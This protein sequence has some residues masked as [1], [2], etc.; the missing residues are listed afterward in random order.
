MRTVRFLPWTC[1]WLACSAPVSE[2]VVEGGQ[3]EDTTGQHLTRR[4]GALYQGG[5]PDSAAVLMQSLLDAPSGE[6]SAKARSTAHNLLGIHAQR[7][8]RFDESIA[9]HK[10]ALA[11]CQELG[12]RDCM[13]R[14]HV[15]LCNTH[16]FKGDHENALLHAYEA[17]RIKEEQADSA[18]LA[19]AHHNLAM[20]HQEQ[21]DLPSA[22]RALAA[23]LAIK[24]RM[25]DSL[26]VRNTLSVMSLVALDR[27]DH[28]GAVL[29]LERAHAI[30]R[31]HEDKGSMVD[32]HTNLGLAH[33]GAGRR[34]EAMRWFREAMEAVEEEPNDAHRAIIT[35]NIGRMLMEEG[36]VAEAGPW[37]EESLALARDVGALLDEKIGLVALAAQ[38]KAQ[39]RHSE[40][41]ELT[42]QLLAVNDSLLNERNQH[43]M[44]ELRVQYDTDRRDAENRMLLQANALAEAQLARQR[45]IIL[46]LVG[47]TLLVALV[48][49]LLVRAWR[50]RVDMRV[51]EL[52]QQALRAQM[53][54]HFLFNALN[55]VPGLY[56][57]HG[58]AMAT[59]YIGHLG[60]LLRLIL[61]SSAQ[62]IVSV[63]EER[64]LLEHY[65]QVMSLRHPGRFTW[66]ITV[67]PSIDA[68]NSGLPPMLLQPLVENAVLH[69][70]LKGEGQGH[71][72]VH[73]GQDR[74]GLHGR[75]RDNGPGL[76]QPPDVLR[77]AK[78]SGLRITDERIRL[79]NGHA[80]RGPGLV[81]RTMHD[82]QGA[83][84]GTEASFTVPITDIWDQ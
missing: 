22:D 45:I 15:N 41:L 64:E 27:G 67:D 21:G 31:E 66:A 50:R 19:R 82:G 24:E 65:L 4:A 60:Q 68:K 76:A 57:S 11:V 44:N 63:Q 35:G 58:V 9:H 54:P 73:I 59:D 5:Y 71:V 52:E 12:D 69:G 3:Q 56:H 37:L 30:A 49:V 47:G 1:L 43:S 2:A 13:G 74:H 46:T 53:D 32:I 40:A 39:G 28:E 8:G 77:C 23:S 75:V 33:D 29:L 26:G 79:G 55:T 14:A 38:R 51:L 25:G 42:E 36:R 78:P 7:Q 48:V 72:E 18:G 17:M 20:I 61:D 6:A 34:S 70:V 10:Q 84:L 80:R 81:L 62:R 83:V 16:R